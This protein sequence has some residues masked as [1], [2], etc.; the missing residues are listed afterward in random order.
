MITTANYVLRVTMDDSEGFVFQYDTPDRWAA[1]EQFWHEDYPE[2]LAHRKGS[3]NLG[4]TVYAMD[5]SEVIDTYE[6]PFNAYVFHRFYDHGGMTLDEFVE[7]LGDG[8]PVRKNDALEKAKENLK[9]WSDWCMD[10]D[11]ED[12]WLDYMV[13]HPKGHC[14]R[15][16]LQEKWDDCYE[17][18][19]N[20]A[21]MTMFWREL[22]ND[23][24]AILTEYV[25]TQWQKN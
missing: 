12:K 2:V 19:G 24:R 23:N 7:A 16:H 4:I 1:L 8:N 20:K 9:L 11:D 10:W 25:T 14:N 17:K 5:G 15:Q 18:Y 22:D 6:V 21:A 3:D 13:K